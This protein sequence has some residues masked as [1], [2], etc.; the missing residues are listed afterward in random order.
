[1]LTCNARLRP[2]LPAAEGSIREDAIFARGSQDKPNTRRHVAP[3]L[4]LP[5]YGY[6]TGNFA[7]HN[8][9]H[10]PLLD[11]PQAHA[12]Q[13]NDQHMECIKDYLRDNNSLYQEYIPLWDVNHR[14]LTHLP[15]RTFQRILSTSQARDPV[16]DRHEHHNAAPAILDYFPNT[17]TRPSTSSTASI[18]TVRSVTSPNDRI[19]VLSTAT[20]T[21]YKTGRAAIQH[22]S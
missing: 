22:F 18:G 7:P 9:L 15:Q 5:A 10:G 1:M 8:L 21:L 3:R 17:N 6:V 4:S 20:D 11:T 19:D 16:T 12:Y 2:R 14:N 13:N